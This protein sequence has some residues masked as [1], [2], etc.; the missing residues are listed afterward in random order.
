MRLRITIDVGVN[1]GEGHGEDLAFEVHAAADFGNHVEALSSFFNHLIGKNK[2]EGVVVFLFYLSLN[3][4][5][6]D[7][8]GAELVICGKGVVFVY[9][10]AWFRPL[11][12][13]FRSFYL[14]FF[15]SLLFRFL[16]LLLLARLPS[17]PLLHAL[18]ANMRVFIIVL[19]FAH[20]LCFVTDIPLRTQHLY[21]F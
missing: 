10:L 12:Q 11:F 19:V 15:P 13:S 5:N 3:L 8:L 1:I 16:F 14:L 4:M 9:I 7:D 21:F 17:L 20:V 6:V 18:A 2:F